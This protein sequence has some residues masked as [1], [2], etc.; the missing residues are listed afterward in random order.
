MVKRVFPV[1][2]ALLV[3]A[4]VGGCSGYR[5]APTAFNEVINQPYRLGA[6]DK[7]RVTVFEQESLTNTYAVDQSGQG[8]LLHD[9]QSDPQEQ[10]NL[11]G[12][13]EHRALETELRDRLFRR[14][15]ECQP[16]R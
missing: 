15:V 16:V 7:V 13:P 9:L 4:L 2:H 8:Y 14:V 6:G 11:L 3:V 5:P 1:I 10:V 12:H